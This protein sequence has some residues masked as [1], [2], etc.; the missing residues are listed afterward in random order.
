MAN[1]IQR[2]IEDIL[3]RLER[4]PPKRTLRSRL[5][6]AAKGLLR[7]P[8]S[9]LASL[10]RPRLSVGQ[11]ML[12]ALAIIIVAWVFD[13]GPIIFAGLALLLLAFILSLRRRTRPTEKL[14]RGQ[15]MDLE[16]SA[17]DRLRSWWERWRSRR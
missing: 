17:G 2:E 6:D 8:Q 4:F 14:W 5:R 15:P 7:G 9:L 3:S 16:P 10:P 12:L 1:R 13:L 11:L